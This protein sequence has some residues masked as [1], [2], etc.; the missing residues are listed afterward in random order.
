[1]PN[2]LELQNLKKRKEE[3]E[4][5]VE[6]TEQSKK[7]VIEISQNLLYQLTSGKISKEEYEEKLNKALKNKTAEQWL[8]YYDSYIYYY[9]KQINACEKQISSSGRKKVILTLEILIVL[10]LMAILISLFFALQPNMF[11]N[12]G[13]K[14]SSVFQPSKISEV[15]INLYDK[16]SMLFEE[17]LIQYQ[18]VLG[19]PVKWEKYFTINRTTEFSLN[20]PAN[21]ENITLKKI[22][23][24]EEKNISSLSIKKKLFTREIEIIVEK[25]EGEYKIEYET[26]APE[27]SEL[28]TEGRVIKK[29]LIKGPDNVHYTNILSFTQ[30]PGEFN[31]EDIEKL[32]L[33]E[34]KNNQRIETNFIVY[35]TNENELLDYIEWLTPE[36]SEAVFELVIEISKAEHLDENYKFIEDIYEQVKALDGNWSEPIPAEHYVRVT[37][38]QNL[39]KD[40]DITIYPRIVSGNPKIEV[41][42]FNKTEI[43]AE[44]INLQSNEYNKIYLINLQ[45]SQDIFDLKIINGSI[46]IEHI[47]DP[48]QAITPIVHANTRLNSAVLTQTQVNTIINDDANNIAL[49]KGNLLTTEL[50]DLPQ[51][52]TLNDAS[53]SLTYFT[54]SAFPNQGV[55]SVYDSFGGNLLDSIAI[56]QSTLDRTITLIDLETKGLS[57][58][59]VNTLIVQVQNTVSRKS[60]SI[61]VDKISCNIDYTEPINQ[62]PQ[63]TY[64]QTISPQAPTES[65]ITNIVFEV[66][67][68]DPDSV[69]DINDTSVS[70]EFSKIGET[71]RT[72]T[73]SLQSD[74][75]IDTASYLCSVNMQYYDGAGP[76]WNIRV[77]ARDFSNNLAVDFSQTFVYLELKAM[78]I[79]PPSLTW[80]EV[81]PGATN[82]IPGS[83]TTI[84]NTG[85]YEGS[86]IISAKDLYGETRTTE[87]FNAGSFVAD[88][89]PG[90]ASCDGTALQN[91]VGQIIAGSMLSK[92]ASA[93]EEIFYCIPR[94]PS[95]SSQI[96]STSQAGPW[97]IFLVVA[98]AIRKQKKKN[99]KQEKARKQKSNLVNNKDNLIKSLNLITEELKQEPTKE[100]EKII[101]LLI[102]EIKKKYRINNREISGLIKSKEKIE[103]PANIFSKELGALETLTKYLKENLAM[104]YR[105]IAE[106]L[107]RNER[108]IWTAYNKAKQKQEKPIETKQTSILISISVLNSRKLTILESLI[109]F[110]KS[111]NMKFNEIASL[112]NRDQINIWTI[113]SNAVKK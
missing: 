112:L 46:G 37:F 3:L 15:S 74:I 100:K 21:S 105:E 56:T 30:L 73:C 61:Y 41:Y 4:K 25:N 92:G 27:I 7:K 59:E 77:Q 67:V 72:G 1:M 60:Y 70:A 90:T 20:L 36:L 82:Q 38:E 10:V 111:K 24:K 98:I 71:T 23:N 93:Q 103:I 64:I 11:K 84:T 94:I 26:P 18:A 83:S 9:K 53:C 95:L 57:L 35:D 47:I 50:N 86:I 16:E 33:Y 19:Q 102:N 17:P 58:S 66:Q 34:I 69:N 110:L 14:I 42:E 65:S 13:E 80:P 79:F 89:D 43:I 6:F 52:G 62:P 106:L 107:N 54:D 108:T 8:A 40:K 68:T 12:I 5:A 97:T 48:V 39:T 78:I 45:N 28:E 51:I 91:S 109:L 81:T 44:F 88:I 75:D 49:T 85:N 63:I 76:D 101:K 96:Y 2:K 87:F 104:S 55:F 113:Y 99:I 22:E 29:V 32:K 31:K